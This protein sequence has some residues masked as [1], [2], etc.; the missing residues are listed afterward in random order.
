MKIVVDDK[1]PYIKGQIEHLADEVLYLPGAAITADDVRDA[2]ILVVRTR[3]HCNRALLEGS[4]VRLVVTAT[5]GF[6]HL[7]TA[8]L[9]EAD[10]EWTNCPGCNATSVA[11]YVR[12]SLYLLEREGRLPLEHEG[13]KLTDCTLAI[14]GVGHVGSAVLEACRPLVRR[15]MLCD[16]PKGCDATLDDIAR[17]ADIV[18]FHTPLTRDGQCPT[19]HLADARFFAQLRRRPV[20]INAA[21][22]GVVDEAALLKALDEG[23]VSE[24]I[25]DTWETEPHFDD[26]TPQTALARVLLNKVYI[27]T[28]HIAGY[29]ADGKANATRM[30]LAAVARWQKA[31]E[32]LRLSDAEV[33]ALLQSIAPPSLTDL[34]PAANPV[35]LALQLYDPRQDSAR[36]KQHPNHFEQLRGDYPLRRERV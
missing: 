32:A 21:R 30:S 18:T 13:R 20:V 2:D 26:S 27:G 25:V 3:T 33:E 35:D 24:A 6:D 14:V 1:I 7:D 12:N 34:E 10:I 19:Y 15:V 29:S 9:A 4:S 36:L 11:Q 22:G 8:Y 5:I 23:R 16:P 31:H 17:E 28:P